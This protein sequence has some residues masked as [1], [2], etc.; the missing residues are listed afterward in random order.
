[1]IYFPPDISSINEGLSLGH[2]VALIAKRHRSYYHRKPSSL[3]YCERCIDAPAEHWHH[4]KPLWACALSYILESQPRTQVDIGRCERDVY[5]N[6][7]PWKWESWGIVQNLASLCRRCHSIC[8][9]ADDLQ[10]KIYFRRRRIAFTYQDV[11]E[12]SL[13]L[14][15]RQEPPP[16]SQICPQCGRTNQVGQGQWEACC[17]LAYQ[18]AIEY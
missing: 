18:F 2:A 13:V 1:M 6:S 7:I 16:I 3:G 9:S 14:R 15:L 4:I 12:I 17:L 10:W 8:Q 5:N 11:M